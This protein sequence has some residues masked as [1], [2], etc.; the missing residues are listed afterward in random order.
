[1][2]LAQL[3]IRDVQDVAQILYQIRVYSQSC[4]KNGGIFA[5][6]KMSSLTPLCAVHGVGVKLCFVLEQ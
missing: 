2:S 1:M 6:A 3:N 5:R 4:T